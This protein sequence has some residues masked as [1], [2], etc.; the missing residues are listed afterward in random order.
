MVAGPKWTDADHAHHIKT[1]KA[2]LAKILRNYQL[3]S[4]QDEE[5]ISCIEAL[6]LELL[7]WAE[8]R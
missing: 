6:R 7:A 4:V 2:Y 1:E 3:F 5:L 8:G